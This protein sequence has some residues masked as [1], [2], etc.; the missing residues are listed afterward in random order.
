MGGGGWGGAVDTGHDTIKVCLSVCV[1]AYVSLDV[2]AAGDGCIR[3]FAE[4]WSP[5]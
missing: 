3:G 2:R 1:C 5:I 4:L